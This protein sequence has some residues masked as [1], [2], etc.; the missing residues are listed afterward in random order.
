MPCD[1]QVESVLLVV[2]GYNMH[3]II[4]HYA[5]YEDHHHIVTHSLRNLN[6]KDSVRLGGAL[7]LHHP[8]L[9]KMR[10]LPSMIIIYV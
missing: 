9:T 10:D 3:K 6:D 1:F 2:H 4:N 8:K 7:G 5:D